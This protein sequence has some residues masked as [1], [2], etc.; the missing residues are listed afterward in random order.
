MLPEG[1][2]G[3]ENL[4]SDSVHS[5]NEVFFLTTITSISHLKLLIRIYKRTKVLG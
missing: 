5:Q 2:L 4:K 3:P 1:Y